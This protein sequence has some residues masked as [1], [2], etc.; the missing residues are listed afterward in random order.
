MSVWQRLNQKNQNQ[1]ASSLVNSGV[2]LGGVLCGG[3]GGVNGGVTKTTSSNTTS[4][5]FFFS[6]GRFGFSLGLLCSGCVT[7]GRLASRSQFG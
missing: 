2:G 6:L 3:G 5:L 1:K 7:G 4:S